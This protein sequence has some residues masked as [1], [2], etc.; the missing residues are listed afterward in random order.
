MSC[1]QDPDQGIFTSE[2]ALIDNN[3]SDVMSLS[4]G[5]SELFF[6]ASDYTAQDTLYAQAATHGQSIFVSSG[7][8]GSD[9]A[10]QNTAGTA[11]SGIN[12]SAFAAPMVTVAGGTDFSDVL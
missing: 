1:D 12:V 7:D 11:T 2:A 9:S 10:D 6:V 5:E 3:L 8:S 4:Y